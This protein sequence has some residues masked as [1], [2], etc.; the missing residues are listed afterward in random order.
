MSFLFR[1]LGV[2]AVRMQ[3]LKAVAV[4]PW[5]I[6]PLMGV[7][8]DL[9]PLFGRHKLPYITLSTLAAL[10]AYFTVVVIQPGEVLTTLCL[11][12]MF[13]QVMVVDL[14]TEAKYAEKLKE[15]PD[16]GPDLMSFVWGGI[17]AISILS[18]IVVGL[19]I[20]HMHVRW[21]YGFAMPLAA[22]MYFPVRH[23]WIGDA[24]V[25]DSWFSF[26]RVKFNAEKH[27]ILLSVGV[28]CSSLL[29]SALS[30]NEDVP[31]AATFGV[32]V[33]LS[34]GIVAAFI[35]F[36]PPIIWKAQVFFFIQHVCTVSI[37][38]AAFYFFTDDEEQYPEGRTY[39]C[40][41]I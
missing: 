2:D 8:S 22:V 1:D 17:F 25:S 41:S 30:I 34:V 4:T 21:C 13:M 20:E 19:V 27:L 3:T 40:C 36:L 5:S 12:F 35:K 16:H 37:D 38:S 6:K 10:L 32:I 33:M 39:L 31:A 29:I 9:F 24:A 11:F 14:L 23:N 18:Y 28:G 26:Q 7:C 15:H